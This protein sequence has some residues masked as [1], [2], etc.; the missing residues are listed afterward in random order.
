LFGYFF[1]F[2]GKFKI[3]VSFWNLSLKIRDGMGVIIGK[4]KGR[5]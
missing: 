3:L 4:L 1:V 5:L 2:P